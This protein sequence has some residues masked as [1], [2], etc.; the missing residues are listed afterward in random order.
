MPL[1]WAGMDRGAGPRRPDGWKK[2][3]GSARLFLGKRPMACLEN[4]KPF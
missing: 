1:V 2:R 4:R 3:R